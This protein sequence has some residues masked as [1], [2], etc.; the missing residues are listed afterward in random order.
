MSNPGIDQKLCQRFEQAWVNNE[1]CSIASCLPPEDREAFLPTLLELVGID[2]E[3]QWK[4][5]SRQTSHN[6]TTLAAND[7]SQPPLVEHYLETFPQLDSPEVLLPLLQQEFWV[8]ARFDREPAFAEYRERFPDLQIKGA[9]LTETDIAL[10]VASREEIERARDDDDDERKPRLGNFGEYE[11]LEEI[12]RG[13][14]GV[15]FRARQCNANRIV[16]LKVIRSKPNI[17][18][19]Q[20]EFTA[21]LARF[22]AEATITANLDHDHIV[23]VYDIGEHQGCAYYTMNFVD[24]PSLK[25]VVSSGPLDCRRAGGYVLSA[26]RAVHEVHMAG[27]LH[28][29]I[30]P[31]NIMLHRSTD[32]IL[33][34]DFG[35][36]KLLDCGPEI[37]KEGE[38]MGTPSY[39]SPEQAVN[40]SAVTRASDVYSLGATLYHLISARPP[41]QAATPIETLRQVVQQTPVSP[42]SLNP[43]IDRD[44]QTICLKCLRKE[45]EKRYSNCAELAD[46]LQRYLDDRPILARPVGVPERFGRWCRRNPL[47]SAAVL[48]AAACLII[49]IGSLV[50]GFVTV[51]AALDESLASHRE[52]RKTINYFFTQVSEN[53]LLDRPGMQP[54]REDLLRHALEHYQRLLTQR[55]AD[56]QTFLEFG[57]AHYRV[58]CICTELGMSTEAAAAFQNAERV[59]QKL[60][61]QSADDPENI[62]RLAKT[63][64]AIGGLHGRQKSWIK[65]ETAFQQSKSFREKL[66][67]NSKPADLTV[68]DDQRMYA[69]TLMNLGL[70]AR[71]QGNQK[72]ANDYF[73]DATALRRALLEYHAGNRELLRDTAIGF[74]NLANHA[75]DENNVAT[76]IR[77][78]QD[79]I[80]FFEKLL[81]EAPDDLKNKHRLSTC[82]RRLGNLHLETA[83]LASLNPAEMNSK[84]AAP[85]ENALKHFI[86]SRGIIHRLASENP[87]VVAFQKEYA[88]TLIDLGTVQTD[89]ARLDEAEKV[90]A[91]AIELLNKLLDANTPN[92]RKDLAVANKGLA[93]VL[94]DNGKSIQ[95]AREHLDEAVRLFKQLLAEDPANPLY[96]EGHLL[97]I[98]LRETILLSLPKDGKDSAK[99]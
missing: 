49:A 9:F 15:V 35:L 73:A 2:L 22:R 29:D 56:Q 79:A 36:A 16:A 41:F 92:V 14:M 68:V 63:L 30:K 94:Y 64:N 45:P 57:M 76:S 53:V 26:A 47:I 37:T 93:I 99:R 85:E 31:H 46:D 12:G 71:A 11:L 43:Y 51:N 59:Q 40:S 58:G 18:A 38:I 17:P 42:K 84:L 98:D 62:R 55:S 90:F 5:E 28:R 91:K 32:R 87:T 83:S 50:Y 44:L 39:M 23:T 61:K 95:A 27:I 77:H 72:T 88:G 13:G 97:S 82:Y 7:Q 48:S 69:N 6:A 4:N 60:V 24:G 19:N 89:L 25:G 66:I 52:S 75:M 33:V 67:E 80:A 81:E 78:L 21:Q 74:F 96:R 1:P 65:A 8:R 34:A 86:A 54:L 3:F 10:T 70:I 20:P